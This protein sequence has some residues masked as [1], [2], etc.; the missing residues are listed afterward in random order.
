M[1]GDFN[2]DGE[3]GKSRGN[4]RDGEGDGGIHTSKGEGPE[5]NAVNNKRG[6]RGVYGRKSYESYGRF[7]LVGLRSNLGV[8]AELDPP[9]TFRSAW[10]TGQPQFEIYQQVDLTGPKVD[11]LAN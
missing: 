1:D 2:H 4:N 3:E 8:T 5:G 9:W 10:S 6:K 7:P 11:L